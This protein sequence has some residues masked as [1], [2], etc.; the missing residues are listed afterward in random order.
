M[1]AELYDSKVRDLLLAARPAPTI[2]PDWTDVLG[3]GDGERIVRSLPGRRLLVAVVVAALLL[4]AV[5]ASLAAVGELP[6]LRDANSI[7]VETAT[8]EKLV[9]FRLESAF[10]IYPAGTTLA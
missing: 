3:R 6:W 4:F 7:R 9:E 1:A 5:G 2:S 8:A 10:G